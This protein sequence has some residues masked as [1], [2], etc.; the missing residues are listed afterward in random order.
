MSLGSSESTSIGSLLDSTGSERNS[1]GTIFARNVPLPSSPSGSRVTRSDKSGIG[2][3]ENE[4]KATTPR[5]LNLPPRE[6]VAPSSNNP[7][8]KPARSWVRDP[9]VARTLDN[10]G[11]EGPRRELLTPVEERTERT[12]SW[13]GSSMS[14]EPMGKL[15]RIGEFPNSQ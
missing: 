5:P 6:T 3:E 15:G 1:I 10:L 9:Y 2:E 12:K 4:D 11:I 8:P 13:S 14:V 7:Y